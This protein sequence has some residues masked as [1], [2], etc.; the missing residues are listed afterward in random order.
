MVVCELVLVEVDD[1][2]YRESV[3]HE[4]SQL[5][6]TFGSYLVERQ[7]QI[8]QLQVEVTDQVHR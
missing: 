8:N 1:P 7:V 4:L 5:L 6:A 3:D 2:E